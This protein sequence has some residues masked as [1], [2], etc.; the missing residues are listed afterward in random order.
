MRNRGE[1]CYLG[2]S[3]PIGARVVSD[4]CGDCVRGAA[5]GSGCGLLGGVEE[6]LSQVPK[7]HH[8]VSFCNDIR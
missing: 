8:L 1:L 7:S 6:C 5:C 3:G 4:G 2:G